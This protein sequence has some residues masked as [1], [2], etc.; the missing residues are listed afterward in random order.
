MIWQP[1][2]SNCKFTNA[3]EK[4]ENYDVDKAH[5]KFSSHDLSY[6]FRQQLS[7]S[8]PRLSFSDDRQA[9][10]SVDEFVS[11]GIPLRRGCDALRE[12]DTHRHCWPSSLHQQRCCAGAHCLVP[13][14]LIVAIVVPFPSMFRMHRLVTLKCRAIVA[15]QAFNDSLQATGCKFDPPDPQERTVLARLLQPQVVREGIPTHVQWLAIRP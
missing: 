2:V 7:L 14:R 6:A 13:R 8:S 1:L 12:S 15:Q 11:A 10:E 9:F 4:R 5:Q 3:K